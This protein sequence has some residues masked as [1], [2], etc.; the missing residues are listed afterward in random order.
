MAAPSHYT[1]AFSHTVAHAVVQGGI[2]GKERWKIVACWTIW[3][4]KAS[5]KG[6]GKEGSATD[7]KKNQYITNSLIIN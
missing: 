4:I 2:R 7:G 1:S 5:V 6:V 3:V